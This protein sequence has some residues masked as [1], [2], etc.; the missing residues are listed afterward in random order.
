MVV[1]ITQPRV[2]FLCWL[3]KHREMTKGKVWL[4]LE[5]SWI[6][7]LNFYQD[8]LQEIGVPNVC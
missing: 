2:Y 8:N 1:V 5:I 4:C 6:S 7:W 3:G